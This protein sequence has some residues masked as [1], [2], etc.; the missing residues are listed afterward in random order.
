MVFNFNMFMPNITVKRHSCLRQE[1]LMLD[2]ATGCLKI[3]LTVI[4]L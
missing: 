1:A 4:G 3:L 2:A